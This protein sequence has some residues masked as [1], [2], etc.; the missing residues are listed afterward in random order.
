MDKSK[1][2]IKMGK[3]SQEQKRFIQEE[4]IPAFEVFNRTGVLRGSQVPNKKELNNIHRELIGYSVNMSC[5]SCIGDAMRLV[6]NRF[7]ELE[8][9]KPK[10]IGYVGKELGFVDDDGNRNKAVEKGEV[11]K[12]KEPVKTE[13]KSEEVKEDQTP[14]ATKPTA[15]VK[16]RRA[17][18]KAKVKGE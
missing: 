1:E 2:I 16:K 18:A 6:V 11:L 12:S 4:I 7:K 5:G 9:A 3:V 8:K 15:N 17:A 13:A 10:K 14:A